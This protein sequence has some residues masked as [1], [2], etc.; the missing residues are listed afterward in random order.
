MSWLRWQLHHQMRSR[1]GDIKAAVEGA[2]EVE[3]VGEAA[4][5]K[6]KTKVQ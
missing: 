1:V 6:G 5:E 3:R 2:V 4:V